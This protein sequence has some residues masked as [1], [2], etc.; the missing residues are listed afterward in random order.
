MIPRSSPVAAKWSATRSTEPVTPFMCGRND[1][2]TKRI[3]TLPMML[4]A[5]VI[6][7]TSV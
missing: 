1:S 2:V 5:E 4:R 7:T 3:L 6:R